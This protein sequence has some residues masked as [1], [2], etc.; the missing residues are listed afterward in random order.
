MTAHLKIFSRCDK[1][2]MQE[3]WGREVAYSLRAFAGQR[4]YGTVCLNNV[5]IDTLNLYQCR[6]NYSKS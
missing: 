4:T 3:P 5:G 1:I 2:I 6:E